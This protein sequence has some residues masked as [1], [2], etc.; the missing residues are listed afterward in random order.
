LSS[1]LTS[2]LA[3]TTAFF[4]SD[5]ERRRAQGLHAAGADA[6]Q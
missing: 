5:L 2:S 1:R 3:Q 6:M 4:A